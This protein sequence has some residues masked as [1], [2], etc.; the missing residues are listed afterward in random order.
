MAIKQY[1]IRSL[2]TALSTYLST[3]GWTNLTFKEG[4]R[5]EDT[6]VV[7]LIAIRYLP[8]T[9][10]AIQLGGPSGEKLFQRILQIDAYMETEARSLAVT[11]DIMEFLDIVPVT[12]VN[13]AADV[14]GTLICQDTNS[15]YSDNSPPILTNPKVLRWRG[16][17]RATLEA[18]IF[19]P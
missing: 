8:S 18:H 2:S 13:E 16:I 7:P 10:K 15:I 11:D 1:E 9:K 12:I 14:L 17:I 6:I 4:F 3:A 5:S 19:A